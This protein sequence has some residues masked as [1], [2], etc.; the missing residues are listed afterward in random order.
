MEQKVSI[1]CCFFFLSLSLV[2]LSVFLSNAEHLMFYLYWEGECGL[3][4]PGLHKLHRNTLGW[5]S[6]D[7]FRDKVWIEVRLKEQFTIFCVLDHKEKRAGYL[8]ASKASAPVATEDV[9]VC[10]IVTYHTELWHFKVNC[11]HMAGPPY[12]FRWGWATL[13]LR[14]AWTKGLCHTKEW[15]MN[16]SVYKVLTGSATMTGVCAVWPES[17]AS[18]MDFSSSLLLSFMFLSQLGWMGSWKQSSQICGQQPCKTKRASKGQS[19][20]FS[21]S[22]LLFSGS[23]VLLSHVLTITFLPVLLF[24]GIIMLRERWGV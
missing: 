2:G 7:T 17:M 9:Q 13:R 10:C 20:S 5:I 21:F 16:G 12:P 19:V 6:L 8:W 11:Y 18:L 15:Q 24:P 14:L 4:R 23:L 1:F 22:L 3:L